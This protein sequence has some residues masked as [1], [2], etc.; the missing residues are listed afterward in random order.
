MDT[1]VHDLRA[2]FK[3][4]GLPNSGAAIN[5]FLKEHTLTSDQSL[6]DASFWTPVQRQFLCEEWYRDSD[7]CVA[8]DT[9]AA[10][11]QH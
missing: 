4:L 9:L 5:S 7:W 8:I 6:A 2:L 11:L 10:R 3:Q 1:S